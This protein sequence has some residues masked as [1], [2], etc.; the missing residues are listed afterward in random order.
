MFSEVWDEISNLNIR[1]KASG[2]I[3]SHILK[4]AS[5][6]SFNKV[7]NIAS[8]MVQS[9]IFPDHDSRCIASIQDD[10]NSSKS[11]YRPINV[12]SAFPKVFESLLKRQMA[13]FMEPK[14][15]N[16]CGFRDRHRTQHAL[17]RV[18][19]TIRMRID[20]SGVCCM[21]MIDLSKAYDCLPHDL[22]FAKMEAYRFSID[23]LKLMHSYLV[24]R[25]QR[26]K[27][28]ASFSTWQEI[29]PDVPQGSALGPFLFNPF[30][31]DFLY[32]IQYSQVFNFADMHVEKT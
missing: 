26:V 13:P 21:V 9:W 18:I 23:S 12:L 28:C 27:I 11:N 29:K 32:E 24:E 7:T 3:P 10:N 14:L 25:R 16:I 6:L 17:L 15:A 31:N 19:E 20:Q 8:T 4:M 1:K 30:I 5:D 2:Y 22:L